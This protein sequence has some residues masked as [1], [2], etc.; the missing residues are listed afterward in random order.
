VCAGLGG[1]FVLR[2]GRVKHHVMP[3]FSTTP[4]CSDA[5][6]D[7]WLHYFEMR[8]PITHVGTLVTGDLVSIT[9]IGFAQPQRQGDLTPIYSR[10]HFFKHTFFSH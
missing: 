8:A 6:V 5:D 2:E 4:L 10:D 3:D 1:A 7:S 9:L